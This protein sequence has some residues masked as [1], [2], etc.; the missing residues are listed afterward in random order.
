[1]VRAGVLLRELPKV[2]IGA[3]VDGVYRSNAWTAGVGNWSGLT[4]RRG[5]GRS[6]AGE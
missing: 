2:M 5:P 1:M 6:D 3:G 4:R